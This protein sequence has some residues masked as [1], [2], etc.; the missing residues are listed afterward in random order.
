MTVIDH[1][2]IVMEKFVKIFS[3]ILFFYLVNNIRQELF[4]TRFDAKGDLILDNFVNSYETYLN[5]SE[6]EI[7]EDFVIVLGG[8][9]RLFSE[10]CEFW[11]RPYY[12]SHDKCRNDNPCQITQWISSIKDS[13]ENQGSLKEI[14]DALGDKLTEDTFIHVAKY[15]VIREISYDHLFPKVI[16]MDLET[17]KLEVTD[18]DNELKRNVKLVINE[19]MIFQVSYGLCLNFESAYEYYDKNINFKTSIDQD[20][21]QRITDSANELHRIATDFKGVV[22]D[23]VILLSADK[24]Q[25]DEKAQFQLPMFPNVYFNFKLFKLQVT[26]ALFCYIIPQIPFLCL[27][28]QETFI[29]NTIHVFKYQCFKK[30]REFA[31]AIVKIFKSLISQE[32]EHF[33]TRSH[34]NTKPSNKKKRKKSSK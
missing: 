5:K 9:H 27:L 8:F 1:A 3:Y 34:G 23:L 4:K 6:A 33:K 16:R 2:N 22:M 11:K 15:Y 24:T 12:Q 20:R 17:L 19:I 26:M 30:F 32:T 14:I 7:K 10:V 21:Y 31:S 13:L 18:Y 29:P 28:T 25:M